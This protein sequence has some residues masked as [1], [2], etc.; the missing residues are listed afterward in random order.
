MLDT[1]RM[2]R[3]SS[4]PSR[5]CRVPLTLPI[6]VLLLAA[7][8]ASMP[9]VLLTTFSLEEMASQVLKVLV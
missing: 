5:W 9:P 1:L 4:T 7:A 8:A 6:L 3:W 2:K